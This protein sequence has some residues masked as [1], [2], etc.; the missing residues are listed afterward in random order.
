MKKDSKLPF[1]ILAI[2]AESCIIYASVLVK[3]IDISPINLAFYRVG[4]ATP[5]FF[6]ATFIFMKKDSVKKDSIKNSRAIE[7]SA[8]I[9]SKSSKISNK[10]TLKV[11]LKDFIFMLFAGIF[12]A[13]DLVFFN[14]ALRNTSVANVNLISCMSC[15]ILIPLGVLFFSERIK[16]SFFIGV[17]IAVLGLVILIKGKDSNGVSS[18]YGDFL[19]FLSAIGY[20]LFLAFI[21]ALRRRY[22][23]LEIMAYSTLGATFVLFLV[24]WCVEGLELPRDLRE[25]GIVALI[26]FFGQLVGQG[27]FNFILGRLDSQTSFLLLL[28]APVIAATLGFLI[29]GEKLSL[30]EICGI[31]IILLGVY[32]AKKDSL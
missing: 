13:F 1:V 29:L 16:K 6:L 24:A 15:F 14:L 27:F 23:T 11:P 5:F 28:I 2:L 19:A 10:T 22:G 9:D 26:V 17:A 20:A 18:V 30:L 25:W 8:K 4:I 3:M 31:L 7:S 12:F 32:F 21:Y